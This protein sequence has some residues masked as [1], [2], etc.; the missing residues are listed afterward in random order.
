[1][2]RPKE[3]S[4]DQL[5][6]ILGRYAAT[7]GESEGFLFTECPIV[8]MA[9][10]QFEAMIKGVSKE[11]RLYRGVCAEEDLYGTPMSDLPKDLSAYVIENV[12][13]DLDGVKVEVK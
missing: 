5:W 2:K 10:D 7:V 4:A 11:A 12:M 1:M 3:L 9:C 6:H 8:N 13:G